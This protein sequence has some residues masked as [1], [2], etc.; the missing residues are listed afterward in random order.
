MSI[1][2]PTDLHRRSRGARW[3]AR[4]TSVAIEGAEPVFSRVM[5]IIGLCKTPFDVSFLAT[6]VSTVSTSFTDPAV[7]AAS[8]NDGPRLLEGGVLEGGVLE[9][10]VL[11]SG[12]LE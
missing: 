7:I 9:S 2:P 6:S 11:E 1:G 10:G 12:V 3:K 5:S 4:V 8:L